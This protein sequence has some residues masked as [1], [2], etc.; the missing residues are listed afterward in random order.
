MIAGIAACVS[1]PPKRAPHP[2]AEADHLMHAHAERL[3]HDVLQLGR[4]LRRG[5][6]EHLSL[7]ARIGQRRHRLQI[8]MFLAQIMKHARQ[9]MRRRGQ[10]RFRLAAANLSR[11]ADKAPQLNGS[12]DREDR[13]RRRHHDPHAAAGQFQRFARFRRHDHHRLPDIEHFAF[14]QHRFVAEQRTKAPFAR[15]I[16][17]GQNCD[18]AR[19]R[20][21][22]RQLD[23]F[24]PARGGRASHE[25]DEQLVGPRRQVVDEHRRARHMADGRIVRNW[26]ADA[27]H[28]SCSPSPSGRGLG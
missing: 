13:L 7:L 25:A 5:V 12:I 23:R 28:G 6:D 2:L 21:G 8:E 20:L 27:R 4:V 26:F 10:R 14:R 22:V 16:A 15:H 24:D 1:L 9:S 11:R 17:R 18:H 19:H 3:G